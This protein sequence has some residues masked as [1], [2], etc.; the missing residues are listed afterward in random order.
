[1]HFLIHA[2]SKFLNILLDNFIP[3]A[4]GRL[5]DSK[6]FLDLNLDRVL[7]DKSL[8]EMEISSQNQEFIRTEIKLL[9]SKTENTEQ[10]LAQCNFDLTAVRDF[11][12]ERYCEDKEQNQSNF[13]PEYEKDMKR[14]LA[15]VTE[16]LLSLTKERQDFQQNLDIQINANVNTLLDVTE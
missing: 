3:K 9:L 2:F 8:E 16:A 13:T 4:A 6:L 1:M 14:A 12:W 7:S 15:A 10:I 11:F 5:H